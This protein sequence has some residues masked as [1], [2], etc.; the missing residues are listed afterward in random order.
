MVT[1]YSSPTC[2]Y[3]R[4]AKVFFRKHR[5]SFTD[6]DV[7]DPVIAQEMINVSKQMAVPVILIEE[8]GKQEML[9]GFQEEKLK[10][11]LN[12]KE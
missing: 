2:T 10:K 5:V 3:C 6:K 12:I 11:L 4:Q 9:V 7:S 8:G 1:I